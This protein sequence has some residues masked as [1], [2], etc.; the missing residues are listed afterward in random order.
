MARSP[1]TRWPPFLTLL[2]TTLMGLSLWVL[3]AAAA[4]AVGVGL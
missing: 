2:S 1:M 3:I 4:H